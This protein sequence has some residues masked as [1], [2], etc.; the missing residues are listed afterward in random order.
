MSAD[1]FGKSAIVIPQENGKYTVRLTCSVPE[2]IEG[3]QYNAQNPTSP[4]DPQGTPAKDLG[5]GSY[6]LLI[7]SLTTGSEPKTF[8]TRLA[9]DGIIMSFKVAPMN[10]VWHPR[11]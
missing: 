9:S 10:H 2:Y 5:N 3:V 6:E 11:I 4:I 8:M 1:F 7:D